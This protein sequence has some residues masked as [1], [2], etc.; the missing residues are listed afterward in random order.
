MAYTKYS[1]TTSLKSI[2]KDVTPINMDGREKEK[3]NSF[4][5]IRTNIK[6]IS[7]RIN[8]TFSINLSQDELLAMD[9]SQIVNKIL[10]IKNGTSSTS[11]SSSNYSGNQNSRNSSDSETYTKFEVRQYLKSIVEDITSIDMNGKED[12]KFNN[13]YTIRTNIQDISDMIYLVFGINISQYQLLDMNILQIADKILSIQN[14]TSSSSGSNYSE[15]QSSHSNVWS[16]KTNFSE[17]NSYSDEPDSVSDILNRHSN[18][19]RKTFD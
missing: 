6:K 17:F 12:W 18:R 19:I 14:G 8:S 2:I 10:I 7:K 3:L 16:S 1:V 15:S 11:S 4:Y 5:T 13:S 9:I